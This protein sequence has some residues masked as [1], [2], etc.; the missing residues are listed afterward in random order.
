MKIEALA[1]RGREGMLALNGATQIDPGTCPQSM[2]IS[3]IPLCAEGSLAR[4][5]P[6]ENQAGDA[7]LQSGTRR[8]IVSR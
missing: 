6:E 8:D 7:S 3:P 2:R 4:G 1:R 5:L